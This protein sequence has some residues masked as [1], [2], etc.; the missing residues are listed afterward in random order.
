VA[1]ATDLATGVLHDCNGNGVPDEC[2]TAA[3]VPVNCTPTCYANCDASTLIPFLNVNDFTCFLN[4]YAAGDSYAN[5]DGST[6]SPV[7][8]VNDFSCFTNRY[9]AGCASP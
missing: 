1:D 9:A 8:N 4:R 7:L 6:I 3:G 2:E 5:C